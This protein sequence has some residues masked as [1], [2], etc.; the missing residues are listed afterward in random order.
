VLDALLES[1]G[2]HLKRLGDLDV[3]VADEEEEAAEEVSAAGAGLG[4]GKRE[5]GKGQQQQPPPQ[6]PPVHIQEW[7]ERGLGKSALARLHK[8]QQAE[9]FAAAAAL[10]TTHAPTP[11]CELEPH[12]QPGSGGS[13]SLPCSPHGSGAA[14][15]QWVPIRFH[16]PARLSGVEGQPSPPVDG[17]GPA[18]TAAAAA[19][20]PFSSPGRRPQQHQGQGGGGGG[21]GEPHQQH[22]HQHQHQQQ[23]Q[24]GAA[25]GRRDAAVSVEAAPVVL[26]AAEF[27]L[28]PGKRAAFKCGTH[29]FGEPL[30]HLVRDPNTCRLA[31]LEPS[32]GVPYIFEEVNFILVVGG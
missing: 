23:Q 16:S 29:L 17:L 32:L 31:L 12:P 8:L 10:A 4:E 25:A 2:V 14:T 20:S 21:E 7:E 27:M 1:S 19:V 13:R 26:P 24:A 3:V 28:A 5:V 22:Q 15:R 11:P 18:V 30:V 9:A 6:L